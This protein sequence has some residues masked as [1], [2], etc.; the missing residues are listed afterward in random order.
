MASAIATL[1]DWDFEPTAYDHWIDPAGNSWII[2]YQ[3]PSCISLAKEVL[4]H[5]FLEK[6]RGVS[7]GNISSSEVGACHL[8]STGN[9]KPPAQLNAPRP[10]IQVYHA[11][12]KE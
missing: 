7:R 3:E 1:I 8:V 4:Q 6:I 10:C 9:G 11:L 2:D 5:F 12:A